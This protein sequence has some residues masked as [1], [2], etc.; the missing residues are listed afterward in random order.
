MYPKYWIRNIPDTM[1]KLGYPV[2]ANLQEKWFA[3]AAWEMKHRVGPEAVATMASHPERVYTPGAGPHQVTIQWALKYPVAANAFSR[4]I[5]TWNSKTEPSSEHGKSRYD[6]V[7]VAIGKFVKN[8]VI[9]NPLFFPTNGKIGPGYKVEFDL[10]KIGLQAPQLDA[11]AVQ[12]DGIAP[13]LTG[14]IDDFVAAI[15]R[16]SWKLVISGD[17]AF[18]FASTGLP[19]LQVRVKKIGVFLRD[20]YDFSGPQYLGN[21]S[22][23][24]VRYGIYPFDP[25]IDYTKPVKMLLEEDVQYY[26][27]N[28]RSYDKFRVAYKKGGDFYLFSDVIWLNPVGCPADWLTFAVSPPFFPIEF[29]IK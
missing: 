20:T 22:S 8:S 16:A 11:L 21:W 26:K 1:T 6:A 18:T 9:G 10:E 29:P 27:V 14:K 15:F 25:A 17:C 13:P 4:L 28:N 23:S 5:T 12:N 7:E 2:A 3:G 19:S 24:G